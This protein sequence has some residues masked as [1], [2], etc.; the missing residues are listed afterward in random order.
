M[1]VWPMACYNLKPDSLPDQSYTG[2]T[3]FLNDYLKNMHFPLLSFVISD[4]I[5]C[6]GDPESLCNVRY[7]WVVPNIRYCTDSGS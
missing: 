2:I 5:K 6:S 1:L 7:H 4:Q 3:R